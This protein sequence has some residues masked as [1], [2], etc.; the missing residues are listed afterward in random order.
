M[1]E[2]YALQDKTKKSEEGRKQ[3]DNEK[4]IELERKFD[5]LLEEYNAMMGL[6]TSWKA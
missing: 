1:D 3:K 6:Q 2:S 5:L 4:I